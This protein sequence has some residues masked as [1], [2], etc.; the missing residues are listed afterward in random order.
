MTAPRVSVIVCAYDAAGTIGTCLESL[1]AQT[2]RELEV[3]VVDD[4]LT[5]AT[6]AEVE[7]FAATPGVPVRL[8]RTGHEGLAGARNHGIAEAA[9]EFFA[10]VDADD[11]VEP[12]MVERMLARADE[13]GADLVVCEM[14]YVDFETGA[15]LHVEHEGDASLYGGSLL[16]RPGLL[17][18]MGA[19]VCDKLLRRTLF[20]DSGITFP[21]GRIFEDLW[22]TINDEYL[23]PDFNGQDYLAYQVNRATNSTVLRYYDGVGPSAPNW[24]NTE[25]EEAIV[26]GSS[27]RRRDQAAVQEIPVEGFQVSDVE[28]NAV[29]LRDG[30][31]EQCIRTNNA[32]QS[33][34]DSACVRQACTKF[35]GD[36]WQVCLRDRFFRHGFYSLIRYSHRSR[37]GALISCFSDSTRPC[38]ISRSSAAAS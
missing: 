18:H 23:Y 38:M 27:F 6:A 5:D 14:R 30:S 2:S 22:T 13:T 7:R 25:R 37:I 31:I 3:V 12:A 29:P 24:I 15:E 33:V 9:G 8:V 26:F 19:S 36:N 28:H 34:S 11:T 16:E 4:G 20:D 21:A 1:G 35:A 17:S 32:E 10:F